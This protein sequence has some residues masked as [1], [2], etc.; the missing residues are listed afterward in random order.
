[1]GRGR[2]RGVRELDMLALIIGPK[3][4]KFQHVMTFLKRLNYL[5]M[6]AEVLAR[7]CMKRWS[8]IHSRWKAALIRWGL[9]SLGAW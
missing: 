9:E 5:E 7:A 1:M 3:W 6:V 8:S 4:S 2:R